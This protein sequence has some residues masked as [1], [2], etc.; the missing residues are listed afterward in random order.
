[1]G[2]CNWTVG[3]NRT[4]SSANHVK[5]NQLNPPITAF[6]TT[7]IATTTYSTENSASFFLNIGGEDL[8]LP[9]SRVGHAPRPIFML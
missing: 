1:M 6:I 4:L 5:C 9:W 7:I 8:F 3:Y 2:Q